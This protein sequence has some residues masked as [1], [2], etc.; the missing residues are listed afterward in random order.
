MRAASPTRGKGWEKGG[1]GHVER[2]ATAGGTMK[3]IR[4][5]IE[6][7]VREKKQSSDFFSCGSEASLEF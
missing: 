6:G 3:K 7:E 2:G 5:V 1:L 4:D